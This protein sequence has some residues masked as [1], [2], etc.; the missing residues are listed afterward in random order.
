MHDPLH[1]FDK[2]RAM[3]IAIAKIHESLYSR[4]YWILRTVTDL[5]ENGTPGDKVLEIIKYLETPLPTA[6]QV[7]ESLKGSGEMTMAECFEEMRQHAEAFEFA[8]KH[9]LIK[10]APFEQKGE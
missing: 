2:I 7:Q 5:L 3:P 8:A 9:G 4:S 10:H 6:E 1:P